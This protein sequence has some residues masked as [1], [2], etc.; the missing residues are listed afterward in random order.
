MREG[1]GSVPLA[2]DSKTVSVRLKNL[3]IRNTGKYGPVLNIELVGTGIGPNCTSFFRNV[4]S[5]A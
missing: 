2:N 1:Y 3:R 4:I 5:V